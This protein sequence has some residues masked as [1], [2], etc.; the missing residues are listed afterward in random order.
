MNIYLKKDDNIKGGETMS[1]IGLKQ[2]LDEKQLSIVQSELENQKKSMVVAYLL[3][4]FLGGAGAH[5]FYIGKTGSAVT[6][7]ILF[8][9]GW[10]TT[11]LIIGFFLII[12]LYIWV[13]ID[14]FILHNEVNRINQGIERDILVRVSNT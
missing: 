1:N 14:A 9:L 10:G 8:L 11:W 12:P 5:R 13:L 4:F 3:W 2:K 6:M 7:L